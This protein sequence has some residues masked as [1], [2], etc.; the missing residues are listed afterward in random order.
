MNNHIDTENLWDDRDYFLVSVFIGVVWIILFILALLGA[1]FNIFTFVS[2]WDIPIGIPF[3]VLVLLTLSVNAVHAAE[4]TPS[5]TGLV[6]FFGRPVAQISPGF[7]LVFAIYPFKLIIFPR[8]QRQKQYP[9]ENLKDIAYAGDDI[10]EG[11]VAPLF[12]QTKDNVTVK[13]YF[14]ATAQI[15]EPLLTYANLK[16]SMEEI[17][18]RLQDI[19]VFSLNAKIAT[20]NQEK[21]VLG[22]WAEESSK[23]VLKLLK[24]KAKEPEALAH[25][26]EFQKHIREITT[27]DLA[28]DHKEELVKK[29]EGRLKQMLTTTISPKA[30]GRYKEI[31]DAIIILKNDPYRTDLYQKI[32]DEAYAL[33]EW[34]KDSWGVHLPEF[35]FVIQPPKRIS[36]AQADAAKQIIENSMNTSKSVADLIITQNQNTG[37]ADEAKKIGD[38]QNTVYAEKVKIDTDAVIKKETAILKAKEKNINAARADALSNVTTLA[39]EGALTLFKTVDKNS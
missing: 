29:I 32:D 36:D 9:A 7:G 27:I 31:M 16:G 35:L 24:E 25:Y 38:A 2:I 26:H 39:G 12:T 15:Y 34:D 1:Y 21:V 4:V 17:F 3:V 6:F 11:Q 14:M 22:S 23:Q 19:S 37:K 30:N 10:K 18:H 20:A 28:D 5:E 8:N 33:I 13:Y